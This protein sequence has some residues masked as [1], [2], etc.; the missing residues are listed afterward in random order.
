VLAIWKNSK[1][2]AGLSSPI[3]LRVEKDQ[4][5]N[6]NGEASLRPS[7]LPDA[8]ASIRNSKP[9][10][11][12]PPPLH[13]VAPS[14][15]AVNVFQASPTGSPSGSLFATLSPMDDP[16]YTPSSMSLDVETSGE[17]G[18]D[19]LSRSSIGSTSSF[20]DDGDD[21]DVKS[22]LRLRK[23]LDSLERVRYIDLSVIPSR[24]IGF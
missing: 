2:P 3:V 8:Q 19:R 9:T 11:P 15:P 7:D 21:G 22:Q 14:G 10:R 6:I 18:S 17:G 20:G 5:Q 12:L 24:R 16:L 1:H 23:R 13:L 4:T